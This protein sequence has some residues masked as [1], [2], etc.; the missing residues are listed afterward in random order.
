MRRGVLRFR[1]AVDEVS[2]R[3]ERDLAAR[4]E[5]RAAAVRARVAAGAL[6]A[7]AG[8][9]PPQQLRRGRAPLVGAHPAQSGAY[10]SLYGSLRAAEL[11]AR[12]SAVLV[13]DGASRTL[14]FRARE[15][16]RAR[17]QS[18]CGE[19]A[20]RDRAEPRSATVVVRLVVNSPWADVARGAL[21]A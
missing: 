12:N 3:V 4:V 6:R 7:D 10:L 8:V 2:A 21:R 20:A 16:L 15:A 1:R 5:H 13:A 11:A 14:V 9:A 18:C 19:R 17:V